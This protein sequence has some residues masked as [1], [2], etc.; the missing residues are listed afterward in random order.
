MYGMRGEGLGFRYG[1]QDMSEGNLISSKPTRGL[2]YGMYGMRREG[3][4]REL[5]SPWALNIP[6]SEGS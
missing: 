2:G 6:V 5:W 4:V 1:M 3:L